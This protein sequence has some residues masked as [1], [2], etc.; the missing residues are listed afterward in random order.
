LVRP[1]SAAFIGE[2]SYLNLRLAENFN[3]YDALSYGGRVASYN[4][5]LPFVLSMVP[6]FLTEFLPLILG[7][8]SLLLFLLILTDLDIRNKRL[9]ALLL[10]ISPPFL[11]LFSTINDYFVAVFLA[12]L[13]FYLFNKKGKF[14]IS[15]AMTIFVVLPFFNLMISILA[16][17][18]ILLFAIFK[19]K[20][21]KNY[22]YVAVALMTFV[23][24]FYYAYLAYIS[25]SPMNFG[26]SLMG[27]GFNEKL[28]TLF[29]DLG[30]VFGLGIFSVILFIFGMIN[31]WKRKYRNLFVFFSV[32]ILIIAI[33]IKPETLFIFNLFLAV[34]AA[35]GFSYL[36]KKEWSNKL[37]RN[38]T[39]FVL[40]CGLLFSMVS[41]FNETIMSEPTSGVVSGLEFLSRQ[42]AGTVFSYPTRGKWINY[43]GLPNVM[44]TNF[45]FA[46]DV[47]GRWQDTQTLLYTRDMREALEIINKYDIKYIWIDSEMKE[48]LWTHDEEGLLFL[49]TYGKSF[50]RIFNQGGV[51]IWRIEKLPEGAIP[52]GLGTSN[53]KS[54]NAAG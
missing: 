22:A 47:E 19:A 48:A 50:M 8:L 35:K 40:V 54:N 31:V 10:I 28:M 36:F 46:P 5:G 51:Q 11:Y 27:G 43:A 3:T 9:S 17:V 45:I 2:E 15:L 53:K 12:L 29:S 37:I 44:D 42:D 52:R 1:E 23:S 25:G 24:I 30:G 14:K 20:K 32:L 39:I 4:L 6:D 7:I 18:L 34:F 38:L 21:K 16:A 41:F 49:V 26:F 33:F 13:A